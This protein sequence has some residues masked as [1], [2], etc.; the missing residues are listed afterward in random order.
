MSSCIS[1]DGTHV[2]SCTGGYAKPSWQTGVG[3]PA[4]GARDIPD[5]SLFASNGFLGSF[6]IIC[7]ADLS[8]TGMCDLNPPFEDFAGFG[9]TSVSSPAFAGILA[10]VEQKTHSRQ[11][12]ANFVFYKLAAEQNRRIAM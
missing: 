9:G 3:V 4:D 5:V 1:S 11:G 2:A 8:P 12:N 6:Y 10:L 7:E